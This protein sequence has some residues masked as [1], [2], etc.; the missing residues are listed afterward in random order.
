MEMPL[1]S[2]YEWGAFYV[3]GA[4]EIDLSQG[5]VHDEAR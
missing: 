4:S 3:T 5:E 2:P 1:A